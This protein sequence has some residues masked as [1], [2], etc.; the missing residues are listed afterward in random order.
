MLWVCAAKRCGVFKICSYKHTKRQTTVLLHPYNP[1]IHILSKTIPG[2]KLMWQIRS[3]KYYPATNAAA[4]HLAP[5]RTIC[6]QFSRRNPTVR[7]QTL[8]ISP[9]TAR[10]RDTTS[11]VAVESCFLFAYCGHTGSS[12]EL[13]KLHLVI[14]CSTSAGYILS[15]ARNRGRKC[16]A[17]SRLSGTPPARHQCKASGGWKA[18]Q[19]RAA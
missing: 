6:S 4:S 7:D 17:N 11:A 15:A 9:Q 2:H 1:L 5:Y 3:F 14:S 8:N 10:R 16:F 13:C 12:C 18:G 19:R